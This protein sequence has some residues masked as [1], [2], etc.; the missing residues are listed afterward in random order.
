MLTRS[1][2]PL[3]LRYTQRNSHKKPRNSQVSKILVTDNNN[4]K[5]TQDKNLSD[6]ETKKK[7]QGSEKPTK[8]TPENHNKGTQNNRK[9]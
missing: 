8:H 6:K 7:P 3:S 4:A 1:G 2:D 9:S 5:K